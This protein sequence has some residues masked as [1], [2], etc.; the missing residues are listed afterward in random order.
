MVREMVRDWRPMT[1]HH[2]EAWGLE[3]GGGGKANEGAKER[4]GGAKERDRGA[5]LRKARI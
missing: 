4:D 1:G 5:G 2:R 3:G